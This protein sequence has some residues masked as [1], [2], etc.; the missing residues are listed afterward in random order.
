MAAEKSLPL[1]E[2]TESPGCTLQTPLTAAQ[3]MKNWRKPPK[4]EGKQGRA[5]AHTVDTLCSLTLPTLSP[6]PNPGPI[7]RGSPLPAPGLA[8]HILRV[9]LRLS[10]TTSLQRAS[11]LPVL[12]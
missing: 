8:L 4:V 9:T 1:S 12:L 7:L 5:P 11:D 6:W 10:S 2:D 3:C